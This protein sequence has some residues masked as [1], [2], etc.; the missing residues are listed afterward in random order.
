MAILPNHNLKN[1]VFAMGYGGTVSG[2]VQSRGYILSH[3]RHIIHSKYM[4]EVPI[5]FQS[6]PCFAVGCTYCLESYCDS[7]EKYMACLHDDVPEELPLQDLEISLTD[8][9]IK[10]LFPSWCP[11]ISMYFQFRNYI[12]FS[13]I[14]AIFERAQNS[15]EHLAKQTQSPTQLIPPPPPLPK[16]EDI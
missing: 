16:W 10:L 11:F 6:I 5:Q 8:N 12:L 13:A 1:A 3:A 2:R 9:D 15:E 14:N 4:L 7:S